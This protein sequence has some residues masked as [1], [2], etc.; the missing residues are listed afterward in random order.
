MVTIDSVLAEADQEAKLPPHLWHLRRSDEAL[1]R[2]LIENHAKLTGSQR[3]AQI[4]RSWN[5]M[6]EKF[7]KVFPNEYRRA[8]TELADTR[9]KLAA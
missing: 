7:I 1:L 4:L 2:G 8:L 9:R 5:E 3:A 6:R